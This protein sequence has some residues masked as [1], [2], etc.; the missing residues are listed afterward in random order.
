MPLGLLA[1]RQEPLAPGLQRFG[2]VQPQD[3]DVGDQQARALDRGQHLR[4]RRDIAAGEDVF[5]DPGIGD[6]RPLRAADRVQQH[7]AVVGQEL[8]AF[9]EKRVVE[10]QA[11]V[12]EHADRDDAVE[13]FPQVAIVLH[14]EL[15]RA[16]QVLFSRA[17][18]GALPL[19]LRQRDAGDSGAAEF[20]EIKRKP[21][22]AAADVERAL[23]VSAR[24][25][26]SLAARWRFLA[27]WASSSD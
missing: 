4:Q 20:R 13:F 3:L 16:G 22:P 23:A 25:S 12:L 27:S 26:S 24:C 10:D 14:A 6:V 2:V 9:A 8:G 1:V 21:A 15:D 5:G 19:L 11:D 18:A 7:D 17:F